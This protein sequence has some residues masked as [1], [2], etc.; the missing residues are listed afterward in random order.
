[1]A[2]KKWIG[3]NGA[4]WETS[5]N[6]NP[7]G[8]PGTGDRA[9]LETDDR[10]PANPIAPTIIANFIDS[11]STQSGLTRLSNLTITGMVTVPGFDDPTG[12][13]WLFNTD[14][15]PAVINFTGLFRPRIRSNDNGI[16]LDGTTIVAAFDLWIEP[17]AGGNISM[18]GCSIAVGR[19]FVAMSDGIMAGTSVELD[20][21]T[22]TS[23]GGA[24]STY[25]G[26]DATGSPTTVGF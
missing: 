14:A 20:G 1:M 4:A 15:M 11:T 12:V 8:P 9:V 17:G 25:V 26:I 19:H 7:P 10:W 21:A 6:W 5:G 23:T 18:H 13:D 2:D 24:G 22:I 16:T 3:A